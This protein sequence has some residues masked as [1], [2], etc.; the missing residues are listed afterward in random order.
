MKSN[1]PRNSKHI[2]KRKNAYSAAPGHLPNSRLHKIAFSKHLCLSLTHTLAFFFF[3]FFFLSWS[4]TIICW[5][6]LK[7]Q[8]PPH[9]AASPI[10]KGLGISR[11]A[12][13]S[14][15]KNM[16]SPCDWFQH[17]LLSCDSVD[18]AENTKRD[19]VSHSCQKLFLLKTEVAYLEKYINEMRM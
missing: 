7:V 6:H 9:P 5:M 15:I 13:L 1:R 4:C 11:V 10:S 16:D 18:Y 12:C 19:T 3:F 8:H 14:G 2:W 17:L